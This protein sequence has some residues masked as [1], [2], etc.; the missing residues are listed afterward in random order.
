M[1]R[2]TDRQRGSKGRGKYVGLVTT[3]HTEKSASLFVGLCFFQTQG[4]RI[5]LLVAENWYCSSEI[6]AFIH[7]AVTV[8]T[9]IL[10]KHHLTQ[11]SQV[12]HI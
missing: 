7:K 3:T 10:H 6:V 9:G 2:E 5:G 1:E 4:G 8:Y 12:G 11:V